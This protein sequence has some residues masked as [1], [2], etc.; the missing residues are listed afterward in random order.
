MSLRISRYTI[1][2]I[3]KARKRWIKEGIYSYLKRLPG[4]TI[5]ELRDSNQRKEA[6][7]IKTASARDEI[8]IAL[9]EEGEDLSSAQL[10]EKLNQFESKRIAFAIGG[11]DGLDSQI[12]ESANMVLGL[13]RMTF[14]H[15]IALL[16]LIEQIYRAQSISKGTP[17]H[18]E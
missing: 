16:L 2:T 18:R 17:Y 7:A 8:L 14:P 5:K 10:L 13:S 3:G 4:L 12:K 15:E 9:S 11:A 6:L 1:Y